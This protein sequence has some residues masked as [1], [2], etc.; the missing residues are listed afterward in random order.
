MLKPAALCVL[1]L[2]LS[3]ATPVGDL[4]RAQSTA[5]ETPQG[6]NAIATRELVREIQ[7][8]LLRLGLGPGPFDGVPRSRTNGAVR[9]FEAEH[10]LSVMDLALGKPA[11]AEFLAFCAPMP[12]VRCSAT[13]AVPDASRGGATF[14]NDDCVCSGRRESGRCPGDDR[15]GRAAAAQGPT[16]VP[17]CRVP[18]RCRGL[19]HRTEPVHA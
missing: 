11:L 7:F 5:A 18:L 14:D 17:V 13:R 19:S 3:C 1:G 15:R 8:M 6:Q 10:G 4:A 9:R 12:P 2:M 16:A